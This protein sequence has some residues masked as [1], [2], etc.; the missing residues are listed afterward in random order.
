MNNIIKYYLII[1]V[2]GA[3][4]NFVA[5]RKKDSVSKKKW[6]LKYF[7]YVLWA[8]GV[9]AGILYFENFY[10]TMSCV[11][12]I[13]GFYEV[14]SNLKQK[15]NAKLV[16]LLLSIMVL[17]FYL[18]FSLQFDK[19]LYLSFFVLICVF[20]AFCQITGQIFGTRKII[21]KISPKKT[22]EGYIGGAFVTIL[23][24]FFVFKNVV[25]IEQTW[26]EIVFFIIG[27]ATLGDL[28]SSMLKR[29]FKIKDFSKLFPGQGGILD[30]Y[31]SHIFAGVVYFC[32]DY[33][34]KHV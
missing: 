4:G 15:N 33:L 29:Y 23:F 14:L 16:I 11:V 30:R 22:L 27:G 28:L 21:K 13:A 8:G 31:D 10:F 12:V 6:W 34:M 32:Y 2:V 7:T 18:L 9:I 19:N 20:D 5:L 26:K 24:V 3:I 25:V 17:F 1:S